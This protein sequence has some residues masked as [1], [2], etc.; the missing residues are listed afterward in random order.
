[1]TVPDDAVLRT[2]HPIRDKT[3]RRWLIGTGVSL[4]G[5][6]FYVV[7][8][9]WLVLQTLGSPALLGSVLMAGALPRALLL[10]IGGV[11]ADRFSARQVIFVTALIRA[12]CVASIATL[13]AENELRPALLYA[14]VIV[15][16]VV[17]AF[18][19]PAQSALL[20]ALVS[21]DQLVTGSALSQSAAQVAAIAGPI[22]AGLAIAHLG[23]DV[24]LY[25]DAASFLGVIAVLY[26]MPNPAR[27]ATGTK[28]SH[29][30]R[31]GIACVIRDRALLGMLAMASLI[32]LCA[33]GPLLIGMAVIAKY[34]LGSPAAYGILVSA[35]AFGGLGGTLL[36][37]PLVK[38][39]RGLVVLG[40][41]GVMAVCLFGIGLAPARLVTLAP[42]FALV[43]S[44]AG[45]INV[46]VG[47]WAMQRAPAPLRGRVSSVLILATLG[48]MPISMAVAGFASAS[49]SGFMF[50]TAGSVLLFSTIVMAVV[51]P[52]RIIA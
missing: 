21:K 8:L 25:I 27:V 10:L 11:V 50:V 47:A 30:V 31:D 4:F 12:L 44:I 43:G 41:A 28:I 22:P 42:L 9:P 33:A 15:F 48:V 49:G 32:N 35:A 24:A 6:Q 45:V 38:L 3:Y 18:A 16:G 14:L 19:L 34:R 17:D 37:A 46:H 13:V 20:P 29:T 7:A 5:D 2:M 51:S 26:R 1:M 52:I 36:A 40:A 23:A 39:R